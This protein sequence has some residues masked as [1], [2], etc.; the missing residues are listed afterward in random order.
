MELKEITF[1]G[2]PVDD[3]DIL[4]RLQ[5][6]LSALLE[7]I[8]GFILFGGGLHV[9][10]ACKIPLWHSLREVWYGSMAFH[11]SY[12]EVQEGDVPFAED[13]VGD[14]F[15]LRDDKVVKLHAEYGQ[16]ESLDLGLEE[17]LD[18]AQRDPVEFLGMHPLIQFTRDGGTLEPGQLLLAYPPFCTVEAGSGV[19]LT[20]VPAQELLE[21]HADLS[22][23]MSDLPHG[24]K[25]RVRVK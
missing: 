18:A 1:T 2:K 13:C 8:N 22:A 4:R 14:Q 7:R 10:G 9:R 21:F 19:H 15:F 11:R 6:D 24:G 3:Q 12:A 17:F 5:P 23:Q 20:A 16:L 25:I